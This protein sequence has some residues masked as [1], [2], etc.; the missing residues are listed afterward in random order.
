MKWNIRGFINFDC[1]GW[2]SEILSS[3]YLSSLLRSGEDQKRLGQADLKLTIEIHLTPFNLQQHT[4]D[5]LCQ[6]Y[7][8]PV[9]F[10]YSIG[11]RL[12]ASDASFDDIH[13]WFQMNID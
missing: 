10:K 8:F 11:H 5:F 4:S 12:F 13:V 9:C 1:V 6:Q 2:W 3:V 7:L